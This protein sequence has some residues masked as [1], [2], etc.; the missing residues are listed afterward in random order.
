MLF[1]YVFLIFFFFST[2]YSWTNFQ[3]LFHQ[4]ASNFFQLNFTSPGSI[5]FNQIKI[6]LNFNWLKKFEFTINSSCMQCYSI[7][8]LKWNLIFIELIFKKINWFLFK[9]LEKLLDFITS[10]LNGPSL[11][12][13]WP[14]WHERTNGGPRSSNLSSHYFAK[15]IGPKSIWGKFNINLSCWLPK[16]LDLGLRKRMTLGAWRKKKL[17]NWGLSWLPPPT[18]TYLVGHEFCEVQ[19]HLIVSL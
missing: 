14:P 3:Y 12:M 7:F 17:N 2:S 6:K 1:R 4:Y 16:N 10:G 9:A 18:R 11:F 15:L 13:G 5:E 19:I 8:S